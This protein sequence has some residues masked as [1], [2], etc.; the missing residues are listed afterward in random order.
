[1]TIIHMMMNVKIFCIFLFY[2]LNPYF[3]QTPSTRLQSEP[4]YA[5]KYLCSVEYVNLRSDKKYN[6]TKVE[7]K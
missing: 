5:S 3:Y 1:M 6:N 7:R 2:V 4:F